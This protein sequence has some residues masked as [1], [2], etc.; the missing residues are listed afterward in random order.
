MLERMPPLPW[1]LQQA[2]LSRAA[3]EPLW[4]GGLVVRNALTR[5]AREGYCPESEETDWLP[6]QFES[7]Y[8]P[9]LLTRLAHLS[10][11]LVCRLARAD[12]LSPELSDCTASELMLIA[13]LQEALALVDAQADEAEPAFPNLQLAAYDLVRAHQVVCVDEY[14]RMLYSARLD[15]LALA[16]LQG[17]P[18]RS[19][20]HP[21]GWFTPR[22]G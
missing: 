17:R 7:C 4:A 6:S 3:V 19:C 1:D 11:Q 20:L 2:P 18:G 21:H 8:T 12:H 10:E 22:T 9:E 15:N 5:A 14:V 13:S 16:E